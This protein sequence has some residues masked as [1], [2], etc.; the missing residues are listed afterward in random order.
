VMADDPA[1]Q[2]DDLGLR[3]AGLSRMDTLR[4]DQWEQRLIRKALQRSGGSVPDAAKM[5]GISRA[6]AY[7]KL[8]EYQ[9]ER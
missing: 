1:I 9:I 2:I 8:S 4:I 3:D 7:R 6:T 5:L